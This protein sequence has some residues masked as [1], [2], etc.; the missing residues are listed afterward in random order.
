[1]AHDMTL[2]PRLIVYVMGE[3]P[4]GLCVYALTDSIFKRC[5]PVKEKP[6]DSSGEALVQTGEIVLQMIA[7]GAFFALADRALSQI[8]Q[9]YH[10][11]TNGYGFMMMAMMASPSL[12][13][14]T[15]SVAHYVDEAVQQTMNSMSGTGKKDGK[16]VGG[17]NAEVRKG[18]AGDAAQGNKIIQPR[19]QQQLA[20]PYVQ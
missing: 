16:N 7:G 13:A 19:T 18:N 5:F 15:K 9:G 17:T 11:P 2:V 8:V 3:V 20:N 10:D 4:M 1:M 14:R 6:L 12:M